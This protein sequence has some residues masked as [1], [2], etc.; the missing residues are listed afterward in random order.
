MNI[1]SIPVALILEPLYYGF[2]W[3]VKIIYETVNNFGLAIIFFTIFMRLILMPF[4]TKQ[5]KN[6]L[7]QLQLSNEINDIKRYYK[8][9]RQGFAMAQQELFKKHKISI[10]SGCL[11]LLLSFLLLIPIWRIISQPLMYI[12]NV[13]AEKISAIAQGLN[14]MGLIG[15]GVMKQ[16]L[17]NDMPLVHAMASSPEAL[18]Q[19]IG[20]GH[21]QASQLI[22]L[23]F[24]GLD[25][26][27][28]PTFIPSKLFG[29]ES[30]TFLP[31][32]IIPIIAVVSSFFVSWYSNKT[33]P[34]M[35]Q[36]RRTKA[37]ASKNPAREQNTDQAAKQAK[38]M[39]WISPAITLITVFTLPAAMGLYWLVGNLM[40]ILQS[41]VFYKLYTEPVLKKIR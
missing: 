25:L 40:M 28:T 36:S 5:H 23:N 32:L 34:L 18:N 12:M 22:N 17:S 4:Q 11:P 15:E 20:Q 9:D 3:L 38:Q 6:S 14:K 29:A 39:S 19:M 24:L 7:K 27:K 30:G 31:L 13:S 33:N 35:I 2:G 10:A 21:F 41:F 16:A 26:G 1:S 8:D 37:L